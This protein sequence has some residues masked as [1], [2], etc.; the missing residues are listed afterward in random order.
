MADELNIAATFEVAEALGADQLQQQIA[1]IRTRFPAS[2]H[3]LFLLFTGSKAADSGLSWCPD[4]TRAAPVVHAALEEFCPEA[5]LLVLNCPRAE[6]KDASFT[7]RLN[8]RV[9]LTS[10]PTLVR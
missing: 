4:C 2:A 9:L 7:Y 3:P 6:Y 1:D 10:V 8:E 5:V